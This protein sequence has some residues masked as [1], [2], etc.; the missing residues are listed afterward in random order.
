MQKKREIVP[1]IMWICIVLALVIN[2]V[3][4]NGSRLFTTRWF[5]F[6]LS[7]R[8][9]DWI[10]FMPWTVSVYLGCYVFWIINYVIGCRQERERAFRFMSADFF[11]KLV[12][13]ACF[14]L[15][16]TTNTRG[17]VMG[18]SLWDELMRVLYRMDAADNLFP[19]IHCLVSWFCFIAVR[20]NPK[21]PKWYK[22]AS[23]VLAACVCISTVTTKQHVCIDI[24]AG[25]ALAEGSYLFVEKS[26]FAG[27][28]TDFVT[29][30]AL[31]LSGRKAAQAGKV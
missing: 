5:H 29:R 20:E 14:L 27:W 22:A 1:R 10:P 28:Y 25:V 31:R 17:V 23:L 8:L 16:P 12:C 13:L 3:A 24:L 2:T 6:D 19:S 4:Y 30:I 18:N 7:N 15:L 9:D 11:S 26:G 21:V